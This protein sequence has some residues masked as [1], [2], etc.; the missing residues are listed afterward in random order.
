MQKDI[1]AHVM[2]TDARTPATTYNNAVGTPDDG[3]STRQ[4]AGRWL[5]QEAHAVCV[6]VQP[7]A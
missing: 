2:G 6:C 4:Q 5:Q 3:L 7:V 1:E